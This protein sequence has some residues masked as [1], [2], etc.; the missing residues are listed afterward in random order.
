M[1][2]REKPVSH[3]VREAVTKFV[4]R[5][6]ELA[7]E[8]AGLP[9]ANG[10]DRTILKDDALR[11]ES[12]VKSLIRIIE[13][14]EDYALWMSDASQ[15]MRPK[16]RAKLKRVPG[17]FDPGGLVDLSSALAA[18]FRIGELGLDSPI[19]KQLERDRRGALARAHRSAKSQNRIPVILNLEREI[20]ERHPK[21]NRRGVARRIA[22]SLNHEVRP[23]TVEKILREHG[24]RR[25]TEQS[26]PLSARE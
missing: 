22:E 14:H 5:L 10:E 15:L 13:T 3:R 23:N 19:M 20:L 25:T 8:T 1:S 12:S 11:L 4:E 7:E 24:A 18:A 21:L 26:S 17:P 16:D 9:S 6:R 2:E